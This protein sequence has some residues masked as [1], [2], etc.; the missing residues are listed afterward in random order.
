MVGHFKER[1]YFEVADSEKEQI[2]R[3]P[4]VKFDA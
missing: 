3:A 4:E 1:E 2:A